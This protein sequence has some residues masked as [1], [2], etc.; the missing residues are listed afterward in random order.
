MTENVY[1]VENIFFG[2]KVRGMGLLLNCRADE[3]FVCFLAPAR[4]VL[5]NYSQRNVGKKRHISLAIKITC[6]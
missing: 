2:A 4:K 1:D 5:K 3:L 6:Q